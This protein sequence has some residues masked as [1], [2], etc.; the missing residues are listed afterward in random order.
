MNLERFRTQLE[1]FL[2]KYEDRIDED[3]IEAG[4]VLLDRVGDILYEDEDTGEDLEDGVS[5]MYE[6]TPDDDA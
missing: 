3:V 5:S 2:E 1:Q 4:N 6:E